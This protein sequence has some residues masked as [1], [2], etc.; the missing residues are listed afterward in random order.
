MND[1]L[2][3]RKIAAI[4]RAMLY[5][6]RGLPQGAQCITTFSKDKPISIEE[7]YETILYLRGMIPNKDEAIQLHQLIKNEHY[8]CLQRWDAERR[9]ELAKQASKLATLLEK[10][11][12]LSAQA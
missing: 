1:D 12:V 2:K 6:L 5:C 11:E 7:L 10:L 8:T 9:P 3:K 4:D